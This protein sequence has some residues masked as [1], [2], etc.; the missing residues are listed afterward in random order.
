MNLAVLPWRRIIKVLLAFLIITGLYFGWRLSRDEPEIFADNPALQFKYGSTGGDKNFGIPFAVWQV[1][2]VLFRDKLPRGREAEGWGAFGFITEEFAD[3]APRPR[4]QRPVGTTM[5]NFMGLERIFLNCAVCHAGV[6]RKSDKDKPEIVL[7]MP[8]NTVDLEGFQ[9]FL[10]TIAQ[11]PRF[12]A[13]D[14]LKAIDDQKVDLDF[15]NRMALRFIGVKQMKQLIENISERFEFT[16]DE[17]AFGPGR[18]DTFSPAKA[19]MN[20]PRQ[21]IPPQER[22]GVVDFPSIWLQEQKRHMWLHWD[23]NNNKLEERN[24]SAAFGTGANFPILDRESVGLMEKWVLTAKPPSFASYFPVDKGLAAQGQPVYQARCA[25]CHG[26]SGTDFSGEWV[27]QTTKIAEIGTDRYRFDNYSYDLM[28]NQSALYVGDAEERFQ[29][30]RK[31]DGYA[32]MPLDGLWLRAPYLHNGSVP[33]LRDLLKPPGER[34]AAFYRGFTVYDPD[35][36]GFVSRPGQISEGTKPYLFC[37]AT[38]AE[39]L[40]QC[41]A[42]APDNRG[43]CDAEICKGNGSFGHDYGTDLADAEKNALIEYLKTF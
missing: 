19:L 12:T 5:R 26:V 42:T 27:G 13:D 16:L 31:S 35:D 23:G 28:L 40:A 41:G 29:N 34:P 3:G 9:N 20:W 43:T 30:F 11:D 21:N 2:P 7:G 39:G 32:N 33:S 36:M 38:K 22:I 24:R 18:F 6:I 8:A 25:K 4:H 1:L 15:I 37:Y 10:T 17:P 14:I